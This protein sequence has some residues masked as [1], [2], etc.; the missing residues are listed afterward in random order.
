MNSKLQA[1]GQQVGRFFK[2]W[3][4]WKVILVAAV[5]LLLLIIALG[6]LLS[7]L[8]GLHRAALEGGGHGLAWQGAAAAAYA[9]LVIV[10]LGMVLWVD[11]LRSYW[12]KLIGVIGI[13]IATSLLW[14]KIAPLIATHPTLSAFVGMGLLVGGIAGSFLVFVAPN[15]WLAWL[16][17]LSMSLVVLALIGIGILDIWGRFRDRETSSKSDSRATAVREDGRSGET[18]AKTVPVTLEMGETWNVEPGDLVGGSDWD[19]T[20]TQPTGRVQTR[21][22]QYGTDLLAKCVSGPKVKERCD[23]PEASYPKLVFTAMEATEF[24]FTAIR[25]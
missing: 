23:F 6:L 20:W 21:L 17:S 13:I 11:E 5:Y 12:F 2:G 10:L 9:I 19:Y 24:A 14:A 25:K 1:L 3:K 18:I 7:S 15:K 8:I 4:V 16:L 22:Y